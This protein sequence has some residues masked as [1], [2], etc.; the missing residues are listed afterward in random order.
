[1]TKKELAADKKT[2]KRLGGAP[3]IAKQF[4]YSGQRVNNWIERGIP[5]AVRVRHK[6]LRR[7]GET[8]Q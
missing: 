2:I 1:M 4:G 5:L 6:E 8:F 3:A 7:E